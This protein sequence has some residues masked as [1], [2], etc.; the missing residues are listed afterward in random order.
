MKKRVSFVALPT[1]VACLTAMGVGETVQASETKKETAVV[2]KYPPYP[3]VWEWVTPY[4]TRMS[5]RFQAEMRP[6]GDVQL[7]FQLKGQS[8][9]PTEDV[10]PRGEEHSLLFFSKR[11]IAPPKDIQASHNKRRVILPNGKIVMILGTSG[12]SGN[13]F[14]EFDRSLA[15]RDHNEQELSH[16]ML[17]YV[18]GSPETFV[19]SG[20]CEGMPYD[21]PPFSYRIVTMLADLI[22]LQDNTFLVVDY[23]HGVVIRFDEQW[24]SKSSLLNRRV[25]VMGEQEV[26]TFIRNEKYLNTEAEGYGLR[27]QSVDGDLYQYLM[28]LKG[29]E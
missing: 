2:K 8:P 11:S 7:S 15:V 21:D 29:G 1:I 5:Y 23:V 18:L 3:D 4:P 28:T 17:F 10:F 24:Q 13:C 25:F 20:M 12:G 16:K 14:R 6:D 27:W 26:Q 22:P 19:P 9:K